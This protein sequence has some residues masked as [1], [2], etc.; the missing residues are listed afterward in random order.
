MAKIVKKAKVA[1][2]KKAVAAP[3]KGSAKKSAPVKVKKAATK[4]AAKKT[5]AKVVKSKV[6]SKPAAKKTVAKKVAPKAKVI[7]KKAPVK[8]PLAKKVVAKK[9]VAKVAPKAKAVTKKAPVAKKVAKKVLAKTVKAPI[10]PIPAKKATSKNIATPKVASK[11]SKP[12]V[13]AKA[14][15]KSTLVKKEAV[16]KA[17]PVPKVEKIKAISKKEIKAAEKIAAKAKMAAV[18][19]VTRSAKDLP[20]KKSSLRNVISDEVSFDMPA[21]KQNRELILS[22]DEKLKIKKILL[23]KCIEIQKNNI[24]IAKVAMEEALASATSEKGAEGEGLSDSYRE[25]MHATR[26]MHARQVHEGTNTLALLNRIQIQE[27]DWVKFGS[28]I[29]TDYQNYFISSG[30]G[31]ITINDE[32]FITVSTLSPLFQIL[33]SKEKGVQF[34]FLDRMYRV[35]EVF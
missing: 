29:I 19:R 35:L 13:V 17:L 31:E 32:A 7:S 30:L 10:K 6:K 4:P 34:M 15:P 12:I 27:H 18:N 1:A 25:T 23:S 16:P 5:P 24:A 2:S 26:D 28:V 21:P 20:K 14:Q 8:K 33:A 3:K 11:V 9:A 22:K